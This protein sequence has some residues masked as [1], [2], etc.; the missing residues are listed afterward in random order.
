MSRSSGM[1]LRRIIRHRRRGSSRRR[2][3]KHPVRKHP[4]NRLLDNSRPPGPPSKG[5]QGIGCG[6][7]KIYP[8]LSKSARC[9]T[10]RASAVCP[11]NSNNS[12]DSGWS[13]SPTCLRSN[14]F[15][16]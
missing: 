15:A 13:I 14:N 1:L 11:R 5:T 3:R 16:C 7:T 12:S 6:V 2:V 8:R 9:R 10:I 4:G